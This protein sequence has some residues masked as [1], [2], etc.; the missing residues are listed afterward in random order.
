MLIFIP[1]LAV[2]GGIAMLIIAVKTDDGLVKDDY[3]SH[4]KNINRT[5]VR[6]KAASEHAL[7]ATLM[8]DYTNNTVTA[9]ITAKPGYAIPDYI[10]VDLLHATRAGNDKT[11]TLQRT[12]GGKYFSVIP[13]LVDG[14]WI[15][16]LSA[17]NW[18]MS[19]HLYIPGKPAVIIDSQKN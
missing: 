11:V 6:D 1:L 9:T 19:G 2:V 8:F 18:R 3:Y 12:P 4:G 14:H 17:D 16:Q 10:N 13:E 5:L 15:I 7:K